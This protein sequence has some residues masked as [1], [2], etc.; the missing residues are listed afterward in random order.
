[1]TE[2]RSGLAT[3]LSSIREAGPLTPLRVAQPEVR[4]AGD[5]G[6]RRFDGH[7]AVFNTR[8]AIGDPLKYGFYEEVDPGAFTKTLAEGDARFLIDHQS[9]L[10][11]ARVSAGDLNLTVDDVGLH[12]D[13]GLDEDLSYVRDLIVNLDKRRITGMSF[14]FYV[15]RDAWSTETEELTTAD[16]D[17]V[18][19][20]VEVRRLIEVRLLEV[21]AVTFPA[22]EE[23]D[24]AARSVV[25]AVRA[26]RY[27]LI[28][29]NADGERSAPAEEATRAEEDTAPAEEATRSQAIHVLD[30]WHR[31]AVARTC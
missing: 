20:E 9:S 6:E 21:S 15:M 8:T 13:A 18:E 26:S 3:G 11:V 17:T 19:V 5:E 24:A 28:P 1:M 14:G 16:G 25:E 30:E 31:D 2:R 22:Y 27:K 12:V 10:I 29:E 7:G 23:T 4:A